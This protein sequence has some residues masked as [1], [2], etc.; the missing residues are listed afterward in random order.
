MAST[1]VEPSAHSD[2]RR[3]RALEHAQNY[4]ERL[5]KL[6]TDQT[7]R[8]RGELAALRRNAGNTLGEGRNVAWF[9]RY[10]PQ[11]DDSALSATEKYRGERADEIYFLVATL[12]ADDRQAL[13]QGHF[14]S[15]TWER[16]CACCV[17]RPKTRRRKIISRNRGGA[18]R[19][20]G[21]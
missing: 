4:I 10:L 18:I 7:G 5:R 1:N 16:L 6:H 8:G 20:N 17:P 21:V 19:R 13:E 11:R 12:F 3:K 14:A 15:A 9:Y 2:D